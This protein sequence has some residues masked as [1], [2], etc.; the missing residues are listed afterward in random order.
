MAK[1]KQSKTKKSASK[2]SEYL[3]E[4]S[5]LIYAETDKDRAGGYAFRGHADSSWEL[6][7]T[8]LRRLGGNLSLA[9]FIKYNCN[10]VEE[11]KN[12]NYHL[13][14]N[15]ILTD[16][17]MLAELRHYSAATAL[18][19]F[20]RDFLVALW[21]ACEPV[22]SKS[23]GKILIAKMG[24]TGDF[25]QLNSADKKYSLE[26]VLKFETRNKDQ[27]KGKS[28]EW[29][30]A[31]SEVEVE[32]EP[33]T[34]AENPDLWYWEP[35]FEINHRLSAQKAIFIFGKPDIE[36]K[37][38]IQPIE[39]KNMDKKDI[40]IELDTCFGINKKT[41]FNDLPG[42]SEINDVHHKI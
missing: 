40:R 21:F 17:E 25:L 23:D 30:K 31:E 3:V 5:C 19:D 13:K 38:V 42:F 20:S 37:F 22:D 26:K 27:S 41:L 10:L 7:S 11:A 35:R 9:D 15:K 2:V 33:E 12:A 29:L 14:E 4:L 34:G 18:I 8:A 16:I 1:K 6:K 32:V 28:N 36:E 39:I 24:N